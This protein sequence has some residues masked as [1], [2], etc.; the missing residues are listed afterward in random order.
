MPD[1]T[2]RYRVK[3]VR[4]VEID[5]EEYTTDIKQIYDSSSRAEVERV[6]TTVVMMCQPQATDSGVSEA[7]L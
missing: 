5:G 2:P 4:T 6:F 1:P 7:S 3:L